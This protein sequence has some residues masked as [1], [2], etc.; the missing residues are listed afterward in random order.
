MEREKEKK[1]GDRCIKRLSCVLVLS[2]TH[3]AWGSC[4]QGQDGVCALWNRSNGTKRQLLVMKPRT[5]KFPSQGLLAR[6][7]LSNPHAFSVGEFGSFC[8]EPPHGRPAGRVIGLESPTSFSVTQCSLIFTTHGLF[9]QTDNSH[10]SS[11]F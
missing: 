6:A 3:T 10:A 4:K 9:E 11:S 2:P 5:K 1:I 8:Q 7:P